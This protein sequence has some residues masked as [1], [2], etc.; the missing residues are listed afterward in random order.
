MRSEKNA[1]NTQ[2]IALHAPYNP[3]PSNAAATH[4]HTHTHP[5]IFDQPCGSL[6]VFLFFLKSR[7]NNLFKQ[8]S[9]YLWAHIVYIFWDIYYITLPPSSIYVS[10]LTFSHSINVI[11]V[12]T[13]PTCG[14][15][16]RSTISTE[17]RSISAEE[18]TLKLSCKWIDNFDAGI[19]MWCSRSC[20]NFLVYFW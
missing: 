9:I 8:A 15:W 3:N 11:N 7:N 16:R 12:R 19:V 2:A 5:A 20:R 14:I 18:T 10:T 13:R 4:T 6:A 17:A 1:S